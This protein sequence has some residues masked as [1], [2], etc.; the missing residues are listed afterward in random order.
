ML[1]ERIHAPKTAGGESSLIDP[2]RQLGFSAYESSAYE[3]LCRLYPATAYEVSKASGL[4]RANVYSILRALEVRGLIQRVT[5]DPVRYAPFD[6][7]EFFSSFA[8]KT[9]ELC[10]DAASKAKRRSKVNE[11]V[12]VWNYRGKEVEQKISEII[13]TARE[14][15][16]IK[17]PDRLIEPHLDELARA[18]SRGVKVILI[19]FGENLERLRKHPGMV[20]FAHEGS[21]VLIGA[22]E[23]ILTIA[24]DS[25]SAMIVS[26]AR[27]P[28]GSYTRNPWIVYAIETM[29][30]HEIFLAEIYKKIG[31]ALDA[32]FG[33]Q[34]MKLR[35]K[36]RPE[37]LGKDIL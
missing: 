24:T 3:T 2:L 20:I 11:N 23:A 26:F 33:K 35:K 32:K 25:G 34:L 7:D 12:Y 13:D 16:W 1:T 31:P 15:V 19:A 21:G 5:D 29:V 27:D 28:V 10:S 9:A 8:K 17:A 18:T 36:Y 37:A 22:N 30:L 4:P 6:P 14:H